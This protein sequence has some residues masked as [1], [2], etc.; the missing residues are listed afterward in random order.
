MTNMPN[1]KWT[2]KAVK[3]GH[4]LKFSSAVQMINARNDE[5]EDKMFK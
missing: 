3:M 2:M 5:Q 1:E 4:D